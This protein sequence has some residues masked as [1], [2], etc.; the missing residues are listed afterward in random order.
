MLNPHWSEEYTHNKWKHLD[1]CFFCMYFHVRHQIISFG[2]WNML[3]GASWN[4][5]YEAC[6]SR[7]VYCILWDVEGIKGLELKSSGHAVRH[8]HSWDQHQRASTKTS[9][10][11][12]SL[13]WSPPTLCVKPSSKY[14]FLIYYLFLIYSLFGKERESSAECV[15]MSLQSYDNIYFLNVWLVFTVL[16]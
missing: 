16:L 1:L 9:I 7:S 2:L 6:C 12:L 13:Y 11:Q 14:V 15:W 5:Y 4:V 8:T 10:A 3:I